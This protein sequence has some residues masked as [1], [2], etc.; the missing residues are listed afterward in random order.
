MTEDLTRIDSAVS[1]LSI[2]P[3]DEKAYFPDD[4][5]N[6]A[7]RRRTSS[8]AAEGVWNIKDLGRS[9]RMSFHKG[10]WH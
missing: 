10:S 7:H 8:L 3:K 6:R 5:A 2:S 4:L 9:P 1:G